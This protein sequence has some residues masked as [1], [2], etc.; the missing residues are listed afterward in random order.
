[1]GKQQLRRQGKDA[2]GKFTKAE[3]GIKIQSGVIQS[4]LNQGS[5]DAAYDA[6]EKYQENMEKLAAKTA[7]DIAL[8]KKNE[9]LSKIQL[10]NME[11]LL[12]MYR[13]AAGQYLEVRKLTIPQTPIP[14]FSTREHVPRRIHI[15]KVIYG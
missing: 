2:M 9:T 6:A 1:M 8:G 12:S 3:E 14:D 7:E 15:R 5:L 13:T 11:I 4:Y 10:N